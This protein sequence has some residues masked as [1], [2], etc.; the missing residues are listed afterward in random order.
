MGGLEVLRGFVIL[1]TV[2]ALSCGLLG[3][4]EGFGGKED[5]DWIYI[6]EVF[7]FWQQCEGGLQRGRASDRPVRRLS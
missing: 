4:I 6:L 1:Y 7:P 5:Y 2:W 3:A